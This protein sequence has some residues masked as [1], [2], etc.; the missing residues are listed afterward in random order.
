MTRK[1]TEFDL[2]L[3]DF[4]DTD[5]WNAYRLMSHSIDAM[6]QAHIHLSCL[7]AFVKYLEEQIQ[8]IEDPDELDDLINAIDQTLDSLGQNHF[9]DCEIFLTHAEMQLEAA[10][11]IL[12]NS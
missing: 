12:N 6:N 5:T 11:E 7:H 1:Y 10:L 9:T 4:S 3:L 8:L 2:P